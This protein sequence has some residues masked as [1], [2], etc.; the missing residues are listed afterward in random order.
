[1]SSINEQ[2]GDRLVGKFLRGL[3]AWLLGIFIVVVVFGVAFGGCLACQ[4]IIVDT[5]QQIMHPKR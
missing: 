2:A 4:A 3:G 1:M 5:G